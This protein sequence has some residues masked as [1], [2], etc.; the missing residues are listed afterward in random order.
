MNVH[1]EAMYVHRHPE[2]VFVPIL[3]EATC[4]AAMIQDTPATATG[5]S[6]AKSC[7][8]QMEQVAK[9][10]CSFVSFSN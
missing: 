6:L 8:A 4:V 9:V 1:L 2:E 7:T 3:T 10:R 5:S